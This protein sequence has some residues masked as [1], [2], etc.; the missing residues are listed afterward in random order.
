MTKKIVQMIV[1][2]ADGEIITA[3]NGLVS[4]DN[5][6]LVKAVKHRAR[7]GTYVRFVEPYGREV[8]ANLDDPENLIGIAAALFTARPGRTRLLEA[9]AEVKEWI[10]QDVEDGEPASAP[11]AFSE[12][13]ELAIEGRLRNALET[14][15]SL[16]S[17]LGVEQFKTK[18]T[19]K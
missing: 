18:E 19:G 10:L 3:A 8:Q 5:P 1:V 4:S 13:E 2:D 16:N 15:E 6:E 12:E 14:D 7:I 17:L 11:A 9:P